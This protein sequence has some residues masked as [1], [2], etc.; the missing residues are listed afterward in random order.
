MTTQIQP[1]SDVIS[2]RVNL[3][4]AKAFVAA[5]NETIDSMAGTI[6]DIKDAGAKD[7][8]V[9]QIEAGFKT[10]QENII[11][12]RDMLC[13]WLCYSKNETVEFSLTKGTVMCLADRLVPAQLKA[14][15][16]GLPCF[17]QNIEQA[18]RQ[19]TSYQ[20]AKKVAA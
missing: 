8:L 6:E 4:G 5:M 20:S 2:I 12:T 17:S 14:D 15:K 9:K 19:M 16:T 1:L 7:S 11:P 18:L 3:R 10:L 13:R